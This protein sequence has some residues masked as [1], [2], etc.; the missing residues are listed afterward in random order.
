MKRESEQTALAAA[1]N[2]RRDVEE[3]RARD[4]AVLENDDA[5]SLK[6]EEEAGV[7]GIRDRCRLREPRDEGLE[8]DLGDALSPRAASSG[9]NADDREGREKTGSPGVQSSPPDRENDL[10]APL[11]SELRLG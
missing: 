6:S 10:P 3:R 4:S 1:G 9:E 7:T 11:N 8:R 5:S 2:E